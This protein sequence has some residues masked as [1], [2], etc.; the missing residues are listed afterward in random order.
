VITDLVGGARTVARRGRYRLRRWLGLDPSHRPDIERPTVFLGSEYGG[1]TIV[2]SLLTPQSVVYSFGVGEDISFDLA[3]IERFGVTV[4][5]FDPTP[6]SVAW[7][8]SQT[9]PPGPL[10][11]EFGISDSDGE[12]SFFRPRRVDHVSYSVVARGS[13][14]IHAPVY[15]LATIVEMLRHQRVDLLKMDIEGFEYCV[16]D[17]LIG[18]DVAV[19]QLLVE[20]HH[21]FTGLG[22]RRTIQAVCRLRENGFRLFHVSESREEYSF[23]RCA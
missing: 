17:D 21:R 12:A 2:P 7:V 22:A 13:G 23:L 11:H 10:F 5:A 3:L 16:I 9:L 15:R 20:F 14:H 18:S 19:D 8:T 6:R 1:W 4:H